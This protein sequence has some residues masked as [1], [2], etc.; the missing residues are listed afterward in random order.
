MKASIFFVAICA[1]FISE[2][3]ASVK[4]R[5][6]DDLFSVRCD[7]QEKSFRKSEINEPYNIS[8]LND[9][10]SKYFT[11][12]SITCIS[13]SNKNDSKIIFDNFSSKN[14]INNNYSIL[15]LNCFSPYKH[16]VLDYKDNILNIPKI[17]LSSFK[18]AQINSNLF[19]EPNPCEVNDI[20]M[21]D[22]YLNGKLLKYY[23]NVR[24]IFNDDTIPILLNRVW[25]GLKKLKTLVFWRIS[26]YI[27]GNRQTNNNIS[28]SDGN[29]ELL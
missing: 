7:N 13:S 15:F 12:D 26:N 27:F 4:F 23:N 10:T 18:T 22:I 19:E 20:D 24:I 11:I 9:F 29:E 21:Y 16:V 14:D 8:R 6:Y 3:N 28:E 1:L 17:G 5:V 25:N 2:C